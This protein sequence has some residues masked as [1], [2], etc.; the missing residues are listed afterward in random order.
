MIDQVDAGR[1]ITSASVSSECQM[2]FLLSARSFSRP[3][4]V[5]GRCLYCQPSPVVNPFHRL[6]ISS[7]A[8]KCVV[9]LIQCFYG[10]T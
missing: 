6:P 2:S 7:G 8:L 5:R 4:N 1:Q 10:V 9:C 3:K